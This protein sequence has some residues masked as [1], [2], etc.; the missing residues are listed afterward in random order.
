MPNMFGGDQLSE[1]YAPNAY[2]K[3]VFVGFE[4][5]KKMNTLDELR[6]QRDDLNAKILELESRDR[7]KAVSDLASIS[8][9]ISKLVTEGKIIAKKYNLEFSVLNGEYGIGGTYCNDGWDSS[10]MHC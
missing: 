5:A 7:Q 10:S 9:E 4:E 3:G 8:E 6:A 2:Y 1:D